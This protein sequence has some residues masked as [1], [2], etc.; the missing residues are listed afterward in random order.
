MKPNVSPNCARISEC[1][2]TSLYSVCSSNARE[3]ELRIGVTAPVD[4]TVVR[5]GGSGGTVTFGVRGENSLRFAVL[6]A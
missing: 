2:N 1:S 4:R 6:D 3:S 5:C